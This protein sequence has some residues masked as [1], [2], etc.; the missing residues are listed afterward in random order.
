VLREFKPLAATINIVGLRFSPHFL[1]H[2][3]AVNYVRSN[4]NVLYPERTLGHSSTNRYVR[5]LGIED[6]KAV[7]NGLSLLSC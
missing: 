2:T 1:R 5:S 3:L 6:L 7:H 4:G